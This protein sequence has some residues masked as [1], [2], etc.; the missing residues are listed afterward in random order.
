M[1]FLSFAAIFLAV[2]GCASKPQAVP[3]AEF[4]C[5]D[6]T[7]L[8]V[9]FVDEK[10]IV[11]L[12]EGLTVTLPQSISASGYW[13]QNDRYSLRGKGNDATW[14]RGSAETECKARDS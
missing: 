5:T 4:T 13:Y 10:A 2:A 9:T 3:T 14:T 7:R 1:R 8:R 6:G 12:P 11:V